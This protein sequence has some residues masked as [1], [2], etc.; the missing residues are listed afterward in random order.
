MLHDHDSIYGKVFRQ[1][2]RGVAIREV[3]TAPRS[4]R[5]NPYAGRPVGSI[6]RECLN[7]LIVLNESS[8]RCV[9]KSYFAHNHRASTHLSLEK[10]APKTRPIQPPERGAVVELSEVGRLHHYS[11]WRLEELFPD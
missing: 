6:L 11:E 2:V 5:Q 10:D 3:L 1:R 9:L 8:L 7:H 4:P